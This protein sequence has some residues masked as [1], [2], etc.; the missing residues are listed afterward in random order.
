MAKN[1]TLSLVLSSGG[2]RGLAHVGVIEELELG[3]IALLICEHSQ[4]ENGF[5]KF[6]GLLCA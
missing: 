1:K 2:A 4:L 6:F 3:I 5:F